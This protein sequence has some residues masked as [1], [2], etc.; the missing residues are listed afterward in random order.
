MV[1][2]HVQGIYGILT[3][4]RKD[5]FLNCAEHQVMDICHEWI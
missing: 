4:K 5:L 1:P 3:E 2:S